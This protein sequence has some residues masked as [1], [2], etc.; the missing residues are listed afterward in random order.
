M[1]NCPPALTVAHLG[2]PGKNAV[3]RLFGDVV[4][5]Q[6]MLGRSRNESADEHRHEGSI[7]RDRAADCQLAEL[8]TRRRATYLRRE[9]A[10]RVE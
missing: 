1:K 9:D 10:R 7:E 6:I 4:D 8:T 2:Q 3:D 5:D